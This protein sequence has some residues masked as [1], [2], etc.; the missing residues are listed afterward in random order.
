MGGGIERAVVLGGAVLGGGGG[1]TV[2][3][4]PDHGVQCESKCCTSLV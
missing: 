4:L 3:W 2:A 1:A